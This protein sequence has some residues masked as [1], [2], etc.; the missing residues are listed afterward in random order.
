[1]VCYPP[2][3]FSLSGSMCVDSMIP[4]RPSITPAVLFKFFVAWVRPRKFG[5]APAAFFMVGSSAYVWGFQV[6]AREF[7]RLHGELRCTYQVR[8][9][10]VRNVRG[11][12]VNL[13]A[14]GGTETRI[15]ERHDCYEE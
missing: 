8:G 15:V 1:M 6:S 10:R 12:V 2:D 9:E 3:V 13:G 7:K 14:F 5:P 4:G 11:R